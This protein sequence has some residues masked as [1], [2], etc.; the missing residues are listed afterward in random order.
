LN[1]VHLPGGEGTG[2]ERRNDDK[3]RDR[4]D[5]DRVDE[6]FEHCDE[7]LGDGLA[8][9]HRRMGDG[10]GA[11]AGLVGECGSAK[12]QD[13]DAERPALES[14]GRES[15]LHDGDET[16]WNS[17]EIGADYENPGGDI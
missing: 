6:G 1:P 2:V 13:Q 14:L 17:L 9:P 3:S 4:T 7:A 16:G 5:D 12:T 8:G 15:P 10:R 11:D